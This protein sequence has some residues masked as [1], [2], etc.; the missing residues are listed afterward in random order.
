MGG[1]Q[2]W[3]VGGRVAL[4]CGDEEVVLLNAQV[5]LMSVGLLGDQRRS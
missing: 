3:V 4:F 1:F 2:G 5:A